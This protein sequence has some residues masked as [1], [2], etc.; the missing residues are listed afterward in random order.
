MLD[1]DIIAVEPSLDE[2]QTYETY[3]GVPLISEHSSA[4][5]RE[6]MVRWPAQISAALKA[7]KTVFVFL[8]K[9]Q[10]H[11]Y[12][13]GTKRN[14]GTPGKP[15]MQTDVQSCGNYDFIPLDLKGLSLA[16]GSFI[17]ITREGAPLLDQFWRE[18]EGCTEYRCYFK[19][20]PSWTTLMTTKGGEHAVAASVRLGEGNLV[21]LPEI[22]WGHLDALAA[23]REAAGYGEDEVTGWS[24][25]Y[26]QFALRLRDNLF[27]LDKRLR[28]SDERTDAPEWTNASVYRF[29]SEADIEGEMLAL[30]EQIETLRRRYAD[31]GTRLASEG[32]LRCLLFETGL[33][34]E[35]AVR[36]ALSILGFNV[37][38][39]EDDQSE[40][41]A[42]FS[43]SEGRFI[44]EV[45]GRDNK[46]IDV[47]KASQLHRNISEDF[48]REDVEEM[49]IGVLFGNPFR[50]SPPAEREAFFTR[51]V[52][53]FADTVKLAL[54]QTPDLFAAARHVKNT[55]DA[56]F[57]QQCREAIA[58]AAG[59]VV[60][61]P[62]PASNSDFDV[63]Q[64]G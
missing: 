27:A 19:S 52:L 53:H 18:F 7:G 46:A 11:F 59:G 16:D 3:Q 48:A 63:L 33:R 21:L 39:F 58:A 42:I 62:Q 43:S 32:E 55:G 8:T 50:L 25:E 23:E 38:H 5:Y 20:D 44:G 57:A 60:E 64:D 29:A 47:K 45:E 37:E 54:V 28:S 36:E 12:Y 24:Q 17:K 61:F 56:A 6:T 4:Q 1:A 34:L 40:F 30:T 31:L 35:A 26:T 51:K 9:F 14:V 49:A 22:T 13:T 15:R 41:D 10:K 2:F